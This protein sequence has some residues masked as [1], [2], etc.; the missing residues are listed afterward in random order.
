[1]CRLMGGDIEVTS[2]LGKGSCFTVRV[3]TGETETKLLKA[4]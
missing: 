4:A 1:M 3:P 2:E